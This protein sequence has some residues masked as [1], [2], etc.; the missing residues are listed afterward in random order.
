MQHLAKR[1]AISD[2]GLAKVC[3]AANVPVPARG[4]WAKL[5]AGKRAERCPLPPRGLGQSDTVHFGES[6]WQNANEQNEA[7][8][9]EPIPPAPVFAPDTE[10]VRAQAAALVRKVPLPLNDSYGWSHQI[11]HAPLTDGGEDLVRTE[12]RTWAE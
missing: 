5:Q 3:A 8:L 4:Y 1:F 12:T 11:A 10:A 6:Q 2:R 9:R 7:L